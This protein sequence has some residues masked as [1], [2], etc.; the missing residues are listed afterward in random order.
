VTAGAA[1]AARDGAR[2]IARMDRHAGHRD[3]ALVAVT[4]VGMSR[5]LDGPLLWLVVVVLLV[6]VALGSLQVLA[7]DDP[8]GPTLGVPI[9]A[10]ILPALAAAA[11]VGVVRLAPFGVWLVPLLVLSFLVVRRTLT[12][13]GRILGAATG[14]SDEDRTHVLVTLLVVGFLAF[15]GIAALI[16]GGLGERIADGSGGRAVATGDLVRLVLADA[17]VGFLLGYRAAAL[18]AMTF[19][20]AA[21]SAVTYAAA[22]AVAALA[23]RAI[24]I[25]RLVGPAAL[26]LVFYLWDA[27]HAA[28]PAR[29]R[30]G[31]WFWQ[32]AALAVL[33]VVVVA[34]NMLVRA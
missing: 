19:V 30:E 1:A 3:L 34:W 14:L 20:D 26:V 16:P 13:E 17:V 29:R 24:A 32:T 4:V 9:E 23:I 7:D 22:I 5:L 25:P 27:Y 11:S 8:A 33:G 31:R 18:R 28:A 6:A 10:L 2:T 15:I 12:V 21:W